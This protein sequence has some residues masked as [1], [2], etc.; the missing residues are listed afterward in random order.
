MRIKLKNIPKIMIEAGKKWWATDPFRQ[1]AIIAYYSIFSLPGLLIL[2][3]SL[4]GYFFGREAVTG[5]VYT[6]ISDTI[7][8][9]AA[10]TVRELI[11][12]ASEAK[13][14]TW[15]TIVGIATII[16][17]ATAVFAQFQKSLNIIWEVKTDTEK[18]GLWSVIRVRLFSFG[19]IISIGFILLVS[20][21]LTSV[22]AA[23]GDWMHR[24]FPE[25]LLFLFQAINFIL[26]L[27]IIALVFA[28]MFKFLPDAKVKWRHVWI[29]AIVT[30]LLFQIGKYGLGLYFGTAEPGA[31]YGAAASVVLILLW[32]SYSSMI[33]FFGAE[34]TKE[35][36][37]FLDGAVRPDENSVRDKERKKVRMEK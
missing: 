6:E 3:I 22:I 23:L 4:A 7:G 27:A 19:L 30:A 32:V 21:I 9:G 13:N 25:F 17:G 18:S 24:H 33:V 11:A 12:K 5:R 20:L 28:L 2:V 14:S 16:A 34:F 35:Y 10:K 36:A 26:S 15:A 31:G 8:E 37:N 1:S 29:G